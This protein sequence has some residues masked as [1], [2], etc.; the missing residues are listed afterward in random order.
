MVYFTEDEVLD[1]V[2][3]VLPW[4]SAMVQCNGTVGSDLFLLG[5]A[6]AAQRPS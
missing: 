6:V 1:D 5:N 4:Y 2:Y 3:I